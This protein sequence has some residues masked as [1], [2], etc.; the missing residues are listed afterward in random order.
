MSFPDLALSSAASC[1]FN[2]SACFGRI[3]ALDSVLKNCSTPLCRKLFIILCS[4]YYHY[5]H[6]QQSFV[7][8]PR[9]TGTTRT[10]WRDKRIHE[11]QSADLTADAPRVPSR[12]RGRSHR[13][14]RCG[15]TKGSGPTRRKGPSSCSAWSL[16]GELA[17][18]SV[19]SYL[20]AIEQIRQT[21][22]YNNVYI[23]LH[24]NGDATVSGEVSREA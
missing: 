5:T 10:T 6:S 15:Y 22:C 8:K 3:F 13:F 11:S 9:N 19:A 1:S 12:S 24:G 2:L 23:V 4:V 20:E 18:Q 21:V 7:S 17:E 14:A 16:S